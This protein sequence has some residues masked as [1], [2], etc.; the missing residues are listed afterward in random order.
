MSCGVSNGPEA[1]HVRQVRWSASLLCD[2]DPDP[3]A[4]VEPAAVD[5]DSCRPLRRARGV[6]TWHT[7]KLRT[8]GCGR[9]NA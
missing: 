6:R 4:A 2:V 5:R 9:S 1:G 3:V 8:S 7:C